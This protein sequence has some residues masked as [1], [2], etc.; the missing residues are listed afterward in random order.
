[1][2]Q[3]KPEFDMHEFLDMVETS[4]F[5]YDKRHENFKDRNLKRKI[6]NEVGE[7][8]GFE[9]PHGSG[10]VAKTKFR[11]ARDKYTKI[12]T[13]IRTA[14]RLN[15]NG[16]VKVPWPYFKKLQTMVDPGFSWK[17]TQKNSAVASIVQA[18]PPTSP[19]VVV[20]KN[21]GVTCNTP[22]LRSSRVPAPAKPEP[23]TDSNPE[24]SAV[25][26]AGE[27]TSPHAVDLED[28]A[29]VSSV[30]SPVASPNIPAPTALAPAPD[31]DPR[32]EPQP[33]EDAVAESED[34]ST[35]PYQE[36]ARFPGEHLE[37]PQERRR[38]QEWRDSSPIHLHCM[39]VASKI[40]RMAPEDQIDALHEIDQ[41]VYRYEKRAVRNLT[42][43]E[44]NYS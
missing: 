8:F 16:V 30:A 44:H 15:V 18:K 4:P 2:C 34:M 11:N 32:R 27:P 33:E 7:H 19:H 12:K 9:G 20:L 21:D 28:G 25:L 41:V 13:E 29:D 22:T 43:S 24:D 3:T 26:D 6:W 10:E 31:S 1:M 14:K 37:A 39:L 38:D 23:S 35:E 17:I 40:R 5:L 36:V 42:T